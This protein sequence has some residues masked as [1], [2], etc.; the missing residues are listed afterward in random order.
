MSN[1]FRE[2]L[3][4]GM[5]V[6][7][8]MEMIASSEDEEDR[9]EREYEIVPEN[10]SFKFWIINPEDKACSFTLKKG[11]SLPYNRKIKGKIP[12]YSNM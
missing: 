8:S 3:K 7:E 11:K 12:L 4:G 9:R 10:I 2:Y 5:E 1:I 6:N